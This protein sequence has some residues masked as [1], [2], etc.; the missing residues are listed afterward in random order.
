MPLSKSPFRLHLVFPHNPRTSFHEGAR[1]LRHQDG[2][3]T[4]LARSGSRPFIHTFASKKK[5]TAASAHFGRQMQGGPL[6]VVSPA[7]NHNIIEGPHRRG[8]GFYLRSNG[9][10]SGGSFQAS[11]LFVC[12]SI[13]FMSLPALRHFPSIVASR[14]AGECLP[15]KPANSSASAAASLWD[16]KSL[17]RRPASSSR[18]AANRE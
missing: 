4:A 12:R 16:M 7:R 10:A 13:A 3:K 9:Q 5:R 2:E 17:R 15:L 6:A 18:M 8:G 14:V 1:G 11:P